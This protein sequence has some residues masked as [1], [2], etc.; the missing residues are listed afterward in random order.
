MNLTIEQL[1]D[2]LSEENPQLQIQIKEDGNLE[3]VAPTTFVENVEIMEQLEQHVMKIV[4]MAASM[5]MFLP[6]EM[7][8]MLKNFA[9]EEENTDGQ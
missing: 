7:T 6:S 2:M 3:V 8:E 5:G 4:Y 1:Y 9:E